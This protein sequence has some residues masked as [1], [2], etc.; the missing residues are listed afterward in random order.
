MNQA[1]SNKNTS[2]SHADAAIIYNGNNRLEVTYDELV[3]FNN[4]L[5]SETRTL[6]ERVVKQTQPPPKFSLD[7]PKELRYLAPDI[8]RYNQKCEQYNQRIA[9]ARAKAISPTSIGRLT[10]SVNADGE[11]VVRDGKNVI[12]MGIGAWVI[13]K[14][15]CESLQRK[16]QVEQIVATFGHYP[17]GVKF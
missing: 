10:V 11:A 15:A 9:A 13:E 14:E 16:A 8:E 3:Q 4:F 17:S 2:S 5:S 6:N 7:E 1:K 12:E